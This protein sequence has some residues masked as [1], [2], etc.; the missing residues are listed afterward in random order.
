MKKL[1]TLLALTVLAAPLSPNATAAEKKAKAEPAKTADEAP[2]AAKAPRPLPFQGTVDAI[3]AA[4]MTFTTKSKD[5]KIHTFTVTKDTKITK[6]EDA[7]ELGD[8]E[9]G[10]IVRGTRIKT[11]ENEWQAVKVMIGAKPAAVKKEGEKKP[12]SKKSKDAETTEKEM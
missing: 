3:D 6:G 5:G 2:A 8:L 4:A 11:G 12:R 1:L 7:A 10:A 9:T